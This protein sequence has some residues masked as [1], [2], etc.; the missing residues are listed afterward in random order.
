MNEK[1]V[2]I[3]YNLLQLIKQCRISKLLLLVYNV[4]LPIFL[5]RQ[6]KIIRVSKPFY[7]KA[8]FN[9]TLSLKN[10]I[11]CLKQRN[12]LGFIAITFTYTKLSDISEDFDANTVN[13][14]WWQYKQ[15]GLNPVSIHYF[16]LGDI[17]KVRWY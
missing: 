5:V 16:K 8:D 1:S 2:T 9:E 3:I 10:L 12:V 14:K 11:T 6:I 7:F 4:L 13:C 15:I 17:F